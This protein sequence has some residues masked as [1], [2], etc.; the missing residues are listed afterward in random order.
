MSKTIIVPKNKEAENALDYDTAS[1]E[2]LV[3]LNLSEQE[4]EKL[5][6]EGVFFLINKVSKCNIDDYEDEHITDLSLISNTLIELN[7]ILD[8]SEKIIKMFEFALI[9]KTSIHFYF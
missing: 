3:E 9:Y 2:Q 5:W 1:K 8:G 7:K 4:F 6:N